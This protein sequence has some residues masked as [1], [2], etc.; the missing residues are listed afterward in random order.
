MSREG[1]FL[2]IAHIMIG[3][4]VFLLFLANEPIPRR[5][6]PTAFSAFETLESFDLAEEARDR[7]FLFLSHAIAPTTDIILRVIRCFGRGTPMVLFS[8]LLHLL[9][10]LNATRHDADDRGEQQG[11]MRTHLLAGPVLPSQ[12][13]STTISNQRPTRT[14]RTTTTTTT[15]GQQIVIRFH[16]A[17]VYKDTTHSG[18]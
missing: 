17:T 5:H 4:T 14:V 10:D 6:L 7:G 16:H 1:I 8:L 3:F 15:T 11:M 2:P 9:L 18:Q 12:Q 13:L